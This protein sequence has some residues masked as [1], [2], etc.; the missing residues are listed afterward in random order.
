MTL[1]EALTSLTATA[2]PAKAA[3]MARYHKAPRRY[4]GVANPA[5][6]ALARTWRKSLPLEDR[7]ALAD[8]LWETDIHEARIAAAN[9]EARP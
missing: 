5:I 9:T 3:D 4:L 2:D 8:A 1:D 6:D 7:L